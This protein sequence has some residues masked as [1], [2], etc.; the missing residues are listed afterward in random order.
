MAREVGNCAA[1]K[2]VIGVCCDIC[3]ELPVS[4]MSG[5]RELNQ[6]L[7]MIHVATSGCIAIFSTLPSF[8]NTHTGVWL[9]QKSQEVT[10]VSM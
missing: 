10:L 5:G 2:L 4:L 7:Q 1:Q 9:L 8:S 3:I 6:L